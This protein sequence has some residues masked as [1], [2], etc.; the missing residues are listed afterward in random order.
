MTDDNPEPDID[1]RTITIRVSEVGLPPMSDGTT[2]G[3]PPDYTTARAVAEFPVAE[4]ERTLEAVYSELERVQRE[5]YRVDAL[6]LGAEQFAH[7]YALAMHDNPY[8]TGPTPQSICGQ[9]FGRAADFDIHVTP[10]PQITAVHG[11]PMRTLHQHLMER[12][13]SR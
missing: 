9:Y 10:E 8:G 2:T 11:T 6:I 3:L 7:L 13:E 12:G 5:N 4:C 1:Q